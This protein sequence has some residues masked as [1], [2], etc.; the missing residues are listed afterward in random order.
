V[1]GLDQAKDLSVEKGHLGLDVVEEVG[2]D[3]VAPVD[4]DGDLLKESSDVETLLVDLGL[5]KGNSV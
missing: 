4:P 1:G 5:Q 2:L 3:Q